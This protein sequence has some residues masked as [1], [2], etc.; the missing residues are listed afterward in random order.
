VVSFVVMVMIFAACP[1]HAELVFFASGRSL[2]VK[3][4]HTE[5]DSLVLMLRGGGEIVC[6]PSVIA[7]IAPD[8]VPYPEPEEPSGI[9][10][11]PEVSAQP[12]AAALSPYAELINTAAA[13]QGVDAKLVRAVIQVESA[14]RAS[15]RSRKGAMG[16][17]QLMPETARRYQVVDPYD[18]KSNIEA[19]IKHLKSLLER[20]QLASA[21]AAYNAGE[22]AVARF[23]GVPPYP[24]T[25]DY[26]SRVLE[27]LR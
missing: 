20:F 23:R 5:G 6:E 24:E 1:A 9:Q 26:V 17:M 22:A 3:S 2:S 4:H 19:G 10:P 11:G 15:A 18:P 21:L 16:L 27:L 14:Y 7:R 8:E 13:D 12:D 25:R